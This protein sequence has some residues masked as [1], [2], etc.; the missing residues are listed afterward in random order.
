MIWDAPGAEAVATVRAWL[1]SAR[2]ADAMALRPTRGRHYRHQSGGRPASVPEN[3]AAPA[4]ATAVVREASDEKAGG[5]LPPA[6]LAM[7]R[8]EE[9]HER[10]RHPWRKAWSVKQQRAQHVGQAQAAGTALAA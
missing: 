6:V 3:G 8:A 2:W 4:D 9:A 1:K 7:L 5:K 10:E